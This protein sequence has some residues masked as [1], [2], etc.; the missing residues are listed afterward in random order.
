[1]PRIIYP[2]KSIITTE[3]CAALSKLYKYVDMS[4]MS[5]KHKGRSSLPGWSSP[6]S[7]SE[8]T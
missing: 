1:M 3:F 2:V 4:I 5:M 8:H 6:T 7:R